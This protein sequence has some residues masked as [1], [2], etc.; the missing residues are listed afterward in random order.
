MKLGILGCGKMATALIGGIL[1]AGVC[2]ADEL[3]LNDCHPAA[4]EAL[5]ARTGATGVADK[6]ELAAQS[7]ALLLC[8]KPADALEALGGMPL[9][10]K[11]VI[12]IVAGLSICQLEAAAGPGVRIVRVMPNTPALIGKGAAAY[13]RGSSATDSDAELVQ[14]IFAAVGKALEVKESLLDA[15]TGLSGSGPAYVYLMIEALADGGVKAGLTRETAQLLAAQTVS[16]AARMVLESREHPGVLKDRVASPGGTTMSGL[17]E[18]ERGG[19]RATLI[20]AVEAATRRSQEL[21]RAV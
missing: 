5:V 19:L 17:H 18:L 1:E 20:S 10:G 16:G 11:L 12:S 13:A 6:S 14:S 3:F 9:E 4:V 8:V 15:V 2:R 21:G 7:A